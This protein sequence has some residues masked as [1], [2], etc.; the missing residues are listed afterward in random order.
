MNKVRD[1]VKSVVVHVIPAL[2]LVTML[3]LARPMD[4]LDVRMTLVWSYLIGGLQGAMVAWA[5][6]GRVVRKAREPGPLVE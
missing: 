2:M 4:A 3:V 5:V 6:F 1:K